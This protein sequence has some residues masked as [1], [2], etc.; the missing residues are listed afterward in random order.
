MIMP[1]L[2]AVSPCYS[3]NNICARVLKLGV[4]KRT[5]DITGIPMRLRTVEIEKV[6]LN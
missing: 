5:K 4:S 2:P 3:L 1:K 6:M